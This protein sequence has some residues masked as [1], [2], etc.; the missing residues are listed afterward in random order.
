[1]R[2]LT[3]HAPEDIRYEVVPDATIQAPGDVIVQVERAAI[4]GSD[5]HV[6]HGRESGIDSGTVMGHELLGRVIE[7]GPEVRRLVAGERVV[8]P[9]TT[10][11]GECFYCERGLSAR[12]T[13]GQLFG[14]VQHGIGLQGAQAE[15]VRVPLADSTL[16]KVSDDLPLDGALLLADVLPTAWHCARMA[17]VGRETVAVVL[18]CGPVGLMAV[19]AAME[20]GAPRVFAVDS[21][22]E[23]L[24]WAA[25]F[26]A[27]PLELAADDVAA[28]VRD[29]TDGRGADAVLEVVG[30]SPAARLAFDLVRPGGVV[31]IVGVHHEDRFPF[32]PVEA[33]DRNLTVRIGRCPARSLMESLIPLVHRRP[34]LSS[35]VTHRRSLS[36]GP[37]AYRLFDGKQDGCIKVVLTP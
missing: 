37:E 9:F 5:L 26:G 10:S 20:Q 33:Y 32:S 35:V 21:V 11:C 4:C 1:L 28:A 16:I 12:C 17:E 2:A 15:Y 23:R 31:S 30:S 3:I 14:W 7:A 13:R 34:E 27:T 22:R 29:A 36:D 24:A 6:F 18:G 8:S 19:V 25:R